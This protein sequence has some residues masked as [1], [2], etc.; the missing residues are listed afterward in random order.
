[1]VRKTRP[2]RSVMLRRIGV[3]VVAGVLAVVTAELATTVWWLFH[4][5]GFSRAELI[6]ER[7]RVAVQHNP[8]ASDPGR[9]WENTLNL[10]PLFG[11]TF[12]PDRP[13]ANNFGFLCE[14][15]FELGADGYRLAGLDVEKPLTVGVFGGSFAQQTGEE[16]D[17][18]AE[19]LAEL[20]PD[21]TPVIVNF[22]VAGHALPQSLS[23]F[24]YFKDMLDVAVFVDGLNEVWNAVDNNRAGYPPEFAK[25]VHYR[26]KLSLGELTPHRFEQTAAILAAKRKLLSLTNFSLRPGLRNSLLVHYFLWRPLAH[27]WSHEVDRRSYELKK[28]YEKGNRFFDVPDERIIDHA[29]NRWL[30]HHRVVHW[31]CQALGIM[32]VHALQPNPAVPD[33][34]RLSADEQR[35]ID[36]SSR[37][38]AWYVYAVAPGFIE[39]VNGSQ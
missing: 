3:V 24:H 34:K 5:G 25:A 36:S 18:F 7:R 20:F 16:G 21:R 31:T 26:Y 17:H 13:G 2:R 6:A 19:T 38:R 15:D 32:D 14:H 1:M 11:Y 28:G 33:S 37:A 27:H 9:R 4:S 39:R 30:S 35:L 29:A 8:N 10:H 23:I 12:H 22:A